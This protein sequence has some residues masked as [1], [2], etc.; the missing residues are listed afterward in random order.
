MSRGQAG[1]GRGNRLPRTPGGGDLGGLPGNGRSAESRL[2]RRFGSGRAD[3]PSR[4]GGVRTLP[5]AAASSTTATPSCSSTATTTAP[6][7]APSTA[8]ALAAAGTAARTAARIAAGGFPPGI[9]GLARSLPGLGRRNFVLAGELLG[10]LDRALVFRQAG[11]FLFLRLF[12]PSFGRGRGPGPSSGKTVS[13][14][15]GGGGSFFLRESGSGLTA[16]ESV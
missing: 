16:S 3:G 5:T 1:Q 12:G 9:I 8:A 7:T 13:S 4:R 15:T 6:S 2:G 11:I 10:L 14:S